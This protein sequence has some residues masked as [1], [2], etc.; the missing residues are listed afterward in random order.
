[1][2]ILLDAVTRSKQESKPYEPYLSQEQSK[3][4]AL[5]VSVKSAFVVLMVFMFGL[6][7]GAGFT[8][9]IPQSRPPLSTVSEAEQVATQTTK[10]SA[11]RFSKRVVFTEPEPLPLTELRHEQPVVIEPI[12]QPEKTLVNVAKQEIRTKPSKL[13][14]NKSLNDTWD[15]QWQEPANDSAYT[16]EQKQLLQKLQ[17]AAK[18]TS[19]QPKAKVKPSNSQPQDWLTMGQLTPDVRNRLPTVEMNLH[20]YSSNP[21]KR[22]VKVNGVSLSEGSWIDNQLQIIEIRPRDV[23]LQFEEQIFVVQ[24]MS[25]W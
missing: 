9:F 16:D 13:D 25:S 18:D 21:K 23:V 4:Y 19:S 1:M 8:W 2:S 11:I 6:V 22:L 7:V 14:M 24:A 20:N 10:E 15:P 3:T 17:K 5:S 12:I